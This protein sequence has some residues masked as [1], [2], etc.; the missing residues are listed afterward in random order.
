MDRESFRNLLISRQEDIHIQWQDA[1]QVLINIQQRQRWIQEILPE[2]SS[3]TSLILCLLEHI[4]Q[5]QFVQARAHFHHLQATSDNYSFAISVLWGT[6]PYYHLNFF[7]PDDFSVF[8]TDHPDDD[9]IESLT[10]D[11]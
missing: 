10:D 1:V 8:Y 4:L 5:Y 6:T 2:Q 7:N 3:P 9:S 11:E